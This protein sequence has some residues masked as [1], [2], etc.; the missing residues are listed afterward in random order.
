MHCPRSEEFATHLSLGVGNFSIGVIQRNYEARAIFKILPSL[1]GWPKTMT[2]RIVYIKYYKER[3]PRKVFLIYRAVFFLKSK[4]FYERT[5][6][7]FELE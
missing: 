3:K 1:E 6:A 7:N 4:T 2:G 5:T